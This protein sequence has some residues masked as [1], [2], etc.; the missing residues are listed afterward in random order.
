MN[1][2]LYI[3]ATGMKSLSEGMNVVTNNLAN[4]ST[5]GFKQQNIQFSDLIYE[6]QGTTGYSW[7][8]QDDSYVALGQMG[9]GVQVDSVRTIFNQ[10]AFESSNTVTDLALSG[11]GFFEVVTPEGETMYTRAG[12][13]RFD[14]E[15]YLALPGDFVLNGYP[16]DSEGNKGGLQPIQIDPFDVLEAKPT[17]TVSLNFN[18]GDIENSSVNPTDPYFSLAQNFDSTQLP[19]LAEELYSY[20]QPIQIYDAAGEAQQLTLYVDGTPST[21]PDN[22]LEFVIAAEATVDNP[23][24]TPLVA[25]TMT[26]NAA[27]EMTG[28]N[29]FSPN[30]DTKDLNNWTPAP[31]TESGAVE[32]DYYGQAITLDFGLKGTL[33][34][35]PASAAAVGT[36]GTLLG[37][38]A[39][40]ESN[41]AATTAR[42]GFNMM[43]QNDQDGYAEGYLGNISITAEGE[44][45]GSYSNGQDASLYEIPVARFISEDG[46]RREGNNLFSATVDSGPAELGQAGTENYATVQ[47]NY[48]ETSNVDM[49]TEMVNMIITQRGFQSNS[50]VVTTADA[51][52]QKA[53]EMKR[54]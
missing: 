52:L 9:M 54:S 46:L 10:G 26:F 48:I 41:A 45:I 39:S 21:E 31:T 37:K 40:F 36:D 13:F 24:P 32:L 11:K 3:G 7:G 47:A 6:S 42:V 20:T 5:I 18:F 22:I 23:T 1:S 34:E 38:M 27:G 16:I 2:S 17:S 14:M 12:N 53:M 30:G 33:G 50:K 28:I 19:P 25:G 15:G 29:Y 35:Q 51:M 49:S 8:A 43:Y 44:V 4:V